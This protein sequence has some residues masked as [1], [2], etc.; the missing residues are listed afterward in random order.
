MRTSH[1]IRRDNAEASFVHHSPSDPISALEQPGTGV[2]SRLLERSKR[3]FPTVW[4]FVLQLPALGTDTVTLLSRQCYNTALPILNIARRVGHG[5][6]AAG[7][8]HV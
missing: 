5:C 4:P 6:S 3:D 7:D 8:N 1:A 2:L